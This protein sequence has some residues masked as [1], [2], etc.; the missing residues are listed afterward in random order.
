MGGLVAPTAGLNISEKEKWR[1]ETRHVAHQVIG[2]LTILFWHPA[3]EL[4][5]EQHAQ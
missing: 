2:I 1:N 3:K 4:M 5:E